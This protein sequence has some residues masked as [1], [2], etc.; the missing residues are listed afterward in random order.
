MDGFTREEIERVWRRVHDSLTADPFI[1]N[2]K[3]GESEVSPCRTQQYPLNRA[4]VY[5]L[6]LL[7]IL[8]IPCRG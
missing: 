2:E 7:F 8:S 1:Q 5:L 4:G 3:H 6:L